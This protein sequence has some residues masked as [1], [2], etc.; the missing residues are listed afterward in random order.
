ME[1]SGGVFFL[2]SVQLMTQTDKVSD[3]DRGSNDG[4]EPV[5]NQNH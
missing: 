5:L 4:S 1:V 2:V 3:A